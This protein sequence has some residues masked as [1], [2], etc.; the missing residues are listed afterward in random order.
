[1]EWAQRG[2]GISVYGDI[3]NATQKAGKQPNVTK[4]GLPP[5]LALLG[6]GDAAQ[7]GPHNLQRPLPT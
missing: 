1:M 4:L 5:E 6:G 7:V 2:W 3:Q